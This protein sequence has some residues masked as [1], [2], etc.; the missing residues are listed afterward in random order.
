MRLVWS[1]VAN[2]TFNFAASLRCQQTFKTTQANCSFCF[3]IRSEL[4][5]AKHRTQNAKYKIRNANASR[6]RNTNKSSSFVLRWLI[7]DLQLSKLDG[8]KREQ[9]TAH[10]N[11]RQVR[12]SRKYANA[13]LAPIRAKVATL[14]TKSAKHWPLLGRVRLD[15]RLISDACCLASCELANANTCNYNYEDSSRLLL[16]FAAA[17]DERESKLTRRARAGAATAGKRNKAALNAADATSSKLEKDLNCCV[18]FFRGELFWLL[19]GDSVSLSA[20]TLRVGGFVARSEI[21][22]LRTRSLRCTAQSRGGR[23]IA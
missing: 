23:K 11:C 21:R 20:A 17:I 5:N 1:C 10:C 13:R 7:I 9:R 4:Q 3:A 6:N 22:R 18:R 19:A 14:A 16:V 12:R 2:S 15:S 8:A